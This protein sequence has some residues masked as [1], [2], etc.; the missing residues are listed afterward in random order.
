MTMCH[1]VGDGN[2]PE[3]GVDS[4]ADTVR[5]VFDGDGDGVRGCHAET[6]QCGQVQVRMRLGSNGVFTADQRLK[7]ASRSASAWT[8]AANAA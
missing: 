7:P 8:A 2:A 5:G 6:V 1:R 3:P 4:R